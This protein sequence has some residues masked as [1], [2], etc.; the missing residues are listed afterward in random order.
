M[1]YN[2]FTID[3][4]KKSFASYV[5]IGTKDDVALSNGIT[6][7]SKAIDRAVIAG[8]D[9]SALEMLKNDLQYITYQL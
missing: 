4:I 5:A 6:E 9:A 1:D 8:E 3:L 2:N 7:L